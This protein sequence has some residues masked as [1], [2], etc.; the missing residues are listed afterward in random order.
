[1]LGLRGLT[2]AK[3]LLRQIAPFEH[4]WQ[5]GNVARYASSFIKS[6]ALGYFSIALVGVAIHISESLPLASITFEGFA[7]DT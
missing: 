5:L 2:E 7:S 6:E 4:A 1:M 3:I